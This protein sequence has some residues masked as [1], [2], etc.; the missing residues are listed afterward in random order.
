M[1]ASVSDIAGR[2]DFVCR[3]GDSFSRVL[4]FTTTVAATVVNG[5]IT[6]PA[7]TSPQYFVGGSFLMNVVDG[8]AN[9]IFAITPVIL[10]NVV[11][12]TISASMMLIPAGNYYY[13]LRLTN[14][15]T[16]LITI[17]T[18]FFTVNADHIT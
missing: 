3:R 7:V 15:D 13:D 8:S 18:G 6:V 11:T 1:G 4:T 10:L 5:I 16:T 9:V 14:A 17:L 2:A 12:I